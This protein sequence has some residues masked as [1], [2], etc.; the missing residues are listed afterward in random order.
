MLEWY[1]PSARCAVLGILGWL[2]VT[3][4]LATVAGLNFGWVESWFYWLASAI[5]VAALA[6]GTLLGWVAA[7]ADWLQ[8]GRRWVDT[9]RITEVRLSERRAGPW[10]LFVDADGR[11]AQ[12]QQAFLCHSRA[13]WDLVHNGLRTSIATGLLDPSTEVRRAVGL[14]EWTPSPR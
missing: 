10:L 9:Y 12:I 2:V 14:P 13:L 4:A 8:C 3:A 5:V 7:G 6:L 1:R 11:E